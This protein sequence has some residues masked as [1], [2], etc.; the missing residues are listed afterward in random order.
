M[1]HAISS[2]N[3]PGSVETEYGRFARDFARLEVLRNRDSHID[4]GKCVFI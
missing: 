4:A 1:D 2:T 3:K